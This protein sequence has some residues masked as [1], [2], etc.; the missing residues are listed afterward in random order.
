MDPPT[1]AR[2]NP[3]DQPLDGPLMTNAFTFHITTTRFDE[4]YSPSENSRITTN[5]ANLARGE[6]RQ[7]NLRNAL[8]MIE[9]ERELIVFIMSCV[10]MPL[11]FCSSSPIRPT[12]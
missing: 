11:S 8:T 7:Q 4:H 5:F 3:A 1:S 10:D 6:H 9:S 12:R 2:P